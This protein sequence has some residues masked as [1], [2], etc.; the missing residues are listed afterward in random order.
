MNF[1]A[2]KVTDEKELT[3]IFKLRYKIYVDEWEFE[4]PEK[5]PD[6]IETDE[7]DK[8]SVHFAAKDDTGELIG[9]V[10]L[11]V[12]PPGKFPIEK[13]CQIELKGNEIR[14]ENLAEISRLAITRSYRKR[15]E[16]KYVFGPDEERR[17][18]GSFE[19]YTHKV[20]YK[21]LDDVYKHNV[22]KKKRFLQHDRRKRP[23]I[24]ISLY[25]ALYYESKEREITH[26]Y[27]VMTKGLD[28]LLRKLGI[29]FQ[30]I[31]EPVDYHGIRTPYLGEIKKIE[32]EVSK[33]KPELYK[34]FTQNL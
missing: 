25:K 7:Y 31:G 22:L 34:E 12:N 10:R 30:P 4:K 13:Y 24:I 20:H 11:I 23:E 2:Q 33:S 17:S 3:E 21:R 32:Q 6:G 26:W 14:R 18:I 19:R 16:D 28:A 15:A 9:T 27:A 29:N 8:N 5:H 1:T